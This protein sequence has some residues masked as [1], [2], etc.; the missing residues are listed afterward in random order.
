M[1]VV[2]PDVCV[3]AQ[4]NTRISSF[5]QKDEREDIRV[6]HKRLLASIQKADGIVKQ[7]AERQLHL[8]ERK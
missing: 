6:R 4:E 1:T 3:E 2:T 7:A 5:A 8:S